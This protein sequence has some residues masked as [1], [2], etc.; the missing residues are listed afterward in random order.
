[1]G[2]REGGGVRRVVSKRRQGGARRERGGRE[3]GRANRD[4]SKRK[5]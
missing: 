1:M 2:G 4:V 3:G 5:G